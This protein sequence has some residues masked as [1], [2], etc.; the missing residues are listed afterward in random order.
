MGVLLNQY[1]YMSDPSN[2]H[3]NATTIQAYL[4]GTQQP[5][6]PMGGPYWS[7]QQLDLNAQWM[8]DGFQ[9]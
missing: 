1:S 7:Q 2:N 5:R 6:M 8:T 3:Q 9:P 4:V